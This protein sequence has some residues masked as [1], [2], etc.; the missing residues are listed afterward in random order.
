MT[1]TLYHPNL[2]PQLNW[3]F[4]SYVEYAEATPINL[5]INGEQREYPCIKLKDE[6]SVQFARMN[7]WEIVPEQPKPK[8]TR[9]KVSNGSR[10]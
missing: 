10:K 4:A 9:K 8:K 5:T 7:G 2:T 3:N 1:T 6:S